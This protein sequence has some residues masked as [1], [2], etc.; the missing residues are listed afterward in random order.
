MSIRDWQTYAANKNHGERNPLLK[1][2]STLTPGQRSACSWSK[3]VSAAPSAEM[4]CD[5]PRTERSSEAPGLLT[6]ALHPQFVHVDQSDVVD[7]D[8]RALDK[9]K[10]V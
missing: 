2:L 5:Q 8:G 9:C 4:Q 10:D 7:E 6:K 3:K 1:R